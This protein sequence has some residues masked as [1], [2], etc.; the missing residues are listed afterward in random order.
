MLSLNEFEGRV[1]HFRAALERDHVTAIRDELELGLGD[2]TV[3]GLSLID[4]SNPIERAP[5]NKDGHL[6]LGQQVVGDVLGGQHGSDCALDDPT[7]AAED[8]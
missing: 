6:Q 4:G 3:H 7:I 8:A 2:K 1:V 5:N